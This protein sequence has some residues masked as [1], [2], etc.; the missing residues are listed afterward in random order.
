MVSRSRGIDWLRASRQDLIHHQFNTIPLRFAE[1][2]GSRTDEP[3][4]SGNEEGCFML[5]GDPPRA[6]LARD[7]RADDPS[8]LSR[9]AVE[10]GPSFGKDVERHE[11]PE[12]TDP[13]ASSMSGT[14]ANPSNADC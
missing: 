6:C 2:R 8:A 5:A 4:V 9:D 7:S 12:R 13:S 14:S 11:L 1:S 3:V 10:A